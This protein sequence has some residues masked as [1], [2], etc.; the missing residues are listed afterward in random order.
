MKMK[1][2]SEPRAMNIDSSKGCDEEECEHTQGT[3]TQELHPKVADL[4]IFCG[5]RIHHDA[6]LTLRETEQEQAETY[7]GIDGHRGEPSRGILRKTV[8]RCASDQGDEQRQT[9][10]NGQ[11]TEVGHEHTDGGQDGDLVRITC[12]RGV[13][14]AVGYV[15]KR[16]EQLHR[17]IGH[18][19]IDQ[20][21]CKAIIEAEDGEARKGNTHVEQ[22][23]AVFS[24]TRI[25][26]VDQSTH[27]G[28]PDDVS[29]ITHQEHDGH[30]RRRQSVDVG[31]EE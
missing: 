19:G 7:D 26:L 8:G 22:I 14:C 18:V 10:V 12:Q 3:V 24:V 25:A 13:Q 17:H 16:I 2:G 30:S 20:R 27:D 15:D 29:H 6:L 31:V 9:R 28:V 11:T 4:H 5:F 1:A 23:R 21:R